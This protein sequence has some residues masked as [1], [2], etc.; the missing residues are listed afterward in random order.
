LGAIDDELSTKSENFARTFRDLNPIVMASV[1]R[2]ATG[3][4]RYP[5]PGSANATR[6]NIMKRATLGALCL[7]FAL[8]LLA[9]SA[10]ARRIQL[11][12]QRCISL[13][14]TTSGWQM[15]I[16]CREGKGVIVLAVEPGT[17]HY[18]GSG[19][20]AGLSQEELDATYRSLI[21]RGDSG[22]ELMMVN[23]GEAIL[24]LG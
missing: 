14:Q 20:F 7:V 1:S 9:S 12:K 3:G 24:Q 17:R 13:E 22:F 21:P 5:P 16:L 2:S 23:V 18:R 10:G 6:R 19:V 8:P 15:Q 11:T 4:T